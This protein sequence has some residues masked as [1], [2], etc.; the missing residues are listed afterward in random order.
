MRVQALARL[1]GDWGAVNTLLLE[2]DPLETERVERRRK[3]FPMVASVSSPSDM[4][5]QFDEQ[6][7]A[8][9]TVFTFIMTLFAG[10]IAVGV[11]YN[12]T[13]VALSQRSREL[14]SLRV[15]GYT[16]REIA[17]ILFGEQA[18]QVALAIPLGLV[19]G[20]WM[21]STMMANTDPETYRLTVSVSGTTYAF[22]IAVTLASA[23][24]S[25][26]IVR[27]RIQTLD[28]IAVLKTRE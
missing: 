1:L 20:R 10:I 27:R 24:V 17:T 6:S 14:A 5:R 18:I 15:L 7:A 3:D 12:N 19:L 22:A 28:L 2:V 11:V 25:A 26:I 8:I 23:V 16:R 13:R 9:M 21:S 4:K